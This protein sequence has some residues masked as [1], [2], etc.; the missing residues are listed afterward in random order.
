MNEKF[1]YADEKVIVI[2]T[3]DEE[4]V[5][6][7]IRDYSDNIKKILVQENVIEVLQK[8]LKKKQ[9]ELVDL[10]PYNKLLTRLYGGGLLIGALG[11]IG[12]IG[13]LTPLK[14]DPMI[15]WAGVATFDTFFVAIEILIIRKWILERKKTKREIQATENTI[16]YLINELEKQDEK[17]TELRYEKTKSDEQEFKIEKGVKNGYFQ[18]LD[19]DETIND[20]EQR[21]ANYYNE[22][23]KGKT[24]ILQRFKRKERY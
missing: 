1:V 24:K 2:G 7:S 9:E 19:S 15:A 17:L 18:T 13:L 4:S 11:I 8:E 10:K 23:I 16:T 5:K 12:A 3:D 20:V 6:G 14:S 22:G 21:V